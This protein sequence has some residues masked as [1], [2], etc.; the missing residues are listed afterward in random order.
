MDNKE[1][2]LILLHK[3]YVELYWQQLILK[4]RGHRLMIKRKLHHLKFPGKNNLAK[5]CTWLGGPRSKSPDMLSGWEA[6]DNL[7]SRRRPPI[8]KNRTWKKVSKNHNYDKMMR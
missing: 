4:T 5:I 6:G 7:S 3:N 2:I 8:S 1:K